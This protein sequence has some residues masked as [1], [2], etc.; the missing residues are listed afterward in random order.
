VK[1]AFMDGHYSGSLTGCYDTS[2]RTDDSA[3]AL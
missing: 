1:I 3:Y 2:F